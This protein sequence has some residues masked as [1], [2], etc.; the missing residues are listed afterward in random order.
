[1]WILQTIVIRLHIYI[2]IPIALPIPRTIWLFQRCFLL[3]RVG[4]SVSDQN[5]TEMNL[6]KYCEIFDDEILIFK[7]IFVLFLY[8]YNINYHHMILSS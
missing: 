4:V 6:L 2:P 1:M 5:S 7:A 8:L 3:A